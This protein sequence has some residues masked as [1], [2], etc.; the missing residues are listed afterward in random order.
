MNP[1]NSN[2][3]SNRENPLENVGRLGMKIFLASLS[4]LFIASMMG[5]IV[6]RARAEQWPPE[7]APSLPSGLWLS[8]VVILA[9][10]FTIHLALKR[11]RED[12]PCR[13]RTYLAAT[14]GLG[15]L[16]LT[17]Q[18]ISWFQLA[19]SAEIQLS[20]LYYFLF[21]FLTV[22][23]AAHVIGGLLH[24]GVVFYFA[25]RL[26]YSAANHS[27]IEYAAMYW[28]FLDGVWVVMFI[29]LLIAG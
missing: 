29:M 27:G 12:N 6:V 1:P 2:S 11:I 23:H 13:S 14:F 3:Q 24:L 10:S 25:W 8:T 18:S 20:N 17:L 22:L 16:F 7:G 19:Y 5:Y 28:H 15:I 9:C 21:Y 26:A 4:M